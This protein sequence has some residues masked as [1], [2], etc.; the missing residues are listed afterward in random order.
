VTYED[1][2]YDVEGGV[3][4]LTINR[5]EVYNA[6]RSQTLQELKDAY[7][8]IR[9]D[10]RVG[11]VVLTGAG[12][13]AFCAGG[14]INEEAKGWL[15]GRGGEIETKNL[16]AAMRASLKPTIA[17][18]NGYSVGGGNHLA[19]LCDFSVAADH[20]I[21]GQ[22]GAR[23]GS[24]AQGWLVA[25]LVRVVGAKRAREMW[26]L[27][28]R[29]PASQ[30]LDWGLVN[31]VVPLAELDAEVDRWCNDLL[32]LSP[33]VI[34]VIKRTFDGEFEQ[35]RDYMETQDYLEEINP[36]FF[37]S[38]EQMEGATAFLEKRV[39]DFARWR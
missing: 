11:V 30:M 15:E 17:R 1:I 37:E 32:S 33:T 19:Y 21:F 16:Y 3:A 12:E 20:A 28:R 36:T 2:L 39:P 29:Y 8:Q 4:R 18:I 7:E 34:K 5:P 38:G 25:Y 26:M 22:N 13:K 35:L 9:T 10:N 24:P 31:A 23:V 6:F 14:D 27:C